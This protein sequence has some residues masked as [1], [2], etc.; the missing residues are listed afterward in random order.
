MNSQAPPANDKSVASG[1][2]ELKTVKPL[3]E[4]KMAEVSLIQVLVVIFSQVAIAIAVTLYTSAFTPTSFP[5]KAQ[6]I[7]MIMMGIIAIYILYLFYKL[8]NLN[9]VESNKVQTNDEAPTSAQENI[10]PIKP[11]YT[12]ILVGMWVLINAILAVVVVSSDMELSHQDPSPEIE[13]EKTPSSVT[14]PPMTLKLFIYGVLLSW[15][16]VTAL[17]AIYNIIRGAMRTGDNTKK[18]Q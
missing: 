17:R 14:L 6:E 13:V 12:F 7:C 2:K 8:K 5:S 4:P 10:E 16:C 15:L 11:V 1:Q 18:D 9:E 3:S